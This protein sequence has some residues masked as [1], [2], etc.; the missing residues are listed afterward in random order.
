MLTA[1]PIPTGTVQSLP[2]SVSFDAPSN[3]PGV[4][5]GTDTWGLRFNQLGGTC[6]FGAGSCGAAPPNA[7]VITT[8]YVRITG[9][10]HFVC[11]KENSTSLHKWVSISPRRPRRGAAV[12]AIMN[13]SIQS[14]H[15]HSRAERGFTLIEVL[16][17]IVVL[18]FGLIA[19][20]NLFLVAGSSNTVANQATAASDVAAQIVENLKAQPWNSAQARGHERDL[21]RGHAAADRPDLRRRHHQQLVGDHG[22]RRAH[23]VH[24]RPLRRTGRAGAGP[25][26][27]GVHDLSHVHDARIWGARCELG[28]TAAGRTR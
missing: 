2:R 5:S 13:D 8:N 26:A 3:C 11:L 4:T 20:T 17:A 14:V 27:G 23:E 25:L 19:I 18:V 9:A 22:R 7:G 12:G 24:P 10:G 6:A 21:P 1:D 16:I 15:G 28:F